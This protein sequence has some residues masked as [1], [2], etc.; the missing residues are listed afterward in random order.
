MLFDEFEWNGFM[1][2]IRATRTQRMVPTILFKH[3]LETDSIIG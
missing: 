2:I 3:L 1:A